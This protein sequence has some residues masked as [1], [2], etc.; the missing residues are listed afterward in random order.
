LLNN[1]CYLLVHFIFRF[2]EVN[3]IAK[4]KGTNF[5]SVVNASVNWCFG[6]KLE[7]IQSNFCAK[8]VNLHTAE[9]KGFAVNERTENC[10]V[11]IT[12]ILKTF[13]L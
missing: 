2:C 11:H 9:V 6:T 12:V 8:L 10:H 5:D 3:E 7:G 13:E 4:L 1:E